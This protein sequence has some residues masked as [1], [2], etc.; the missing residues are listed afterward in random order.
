[1]VP[2]YSVLMYFA[3][4]LGSGNVVMFSKNLRDL[5]SFGVAQDFSS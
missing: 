4:T 2:I 3:L 1:M 5:F